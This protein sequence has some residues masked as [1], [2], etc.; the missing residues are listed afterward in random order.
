MGSMTDLIVVAGT[1]DSTTVALPWRSGDALLQRL[2][3]DRRTD[4]IVRKFASAGSSR[5]I[6]LND[7]ERRRLLSTCTDWLNQS[8]DQLPEGIYALRN[9]LLADQPQT[10]ESHCASWSEVA[11]SS[12]GKRVHVG[13]GTRR[14]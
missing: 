1:R 2:V 3:P 14:G 10:L 8:P 13:V 12:V 6:R 7:F 9:A 4:T 11:Q 5:P